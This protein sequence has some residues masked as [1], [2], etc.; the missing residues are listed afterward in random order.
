MLYTDGVVEASRP[1]KQSGEPLQFDETKL[2]AAIDN[3]RGKSAGALQQALDQT[4]SDFYNGH[5][6]VDDYTLLILQR[7]QYNA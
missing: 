3:Q 1:D 2:L 7:K 6:R 5:P 4:L